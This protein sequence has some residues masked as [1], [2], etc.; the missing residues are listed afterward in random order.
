MLI[1]HIRL[2]KN[3]APRPSSGSSAMKMRE[4]IGF[5]EYNIL[6]GR[7]VGIFYRNS[8]KIN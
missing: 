4:N 1:A 6:E 8:Y 2:G 5:L 3:Y 7:I